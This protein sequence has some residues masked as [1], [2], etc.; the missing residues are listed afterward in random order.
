MTVKQ[1]GY[2]A[3]GVISAVVLYYLPLKFALAFLVKLFLI[4]LF[5]GGGVVIAFVPIDGRPIDVM[6]TNF[7]KAF[8]APNQYIYHKTGRK[9]S[10]S[11]ITIKS[12]TAAEAAAQTTKQVT[13]TPEQKLANKK[14]EQLRALL[15]R[16]GGR[17]KNKLD[18]KEMAFFNTIAAT[19]QPH[20]TT[21]APAIVH[22]VMPKPN[23]ITPPAP[24]AATTKPDTETLAKKEAILTQ[25]LAL[26]K[27]D[28]AA[29]GNTPTALSTAHQK[30]L[31]LE[32]QIQLIHA[33]KQQLEQEII[34]LRNQLSTHLPAAPL[35]ATAPMPNMNMS[36]PA[37][38]HMPPPPPPAPKAIPQPSIRN[39]PQGMSKSMGLPHVSDTPNVVL[40]L[41]KDSRGNALPHMLV[42][43]KDKDG[44]PV[45][46][47]KTNVLGQ[48]ASATPL[49]NGTY[50]IALED[51]K[52]LHSFDTIQINP[53]GQ[54]ML[55]I[56]IISHDAREQLRKELFTN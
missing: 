21:P 1:F 17:V 3:A 12:Q 39:I 16:S 4:P 9:F 52:K 8:F 18:E 30:V 14:E 5:G 10:F 11:T 2:V 24:V 27:R 33:Q 42:E 26:A 40:G 22:P 55:P 7:L 32:K 34:R 28:E 23:P 38:V 47:F 29:A 13:T 49:A 54:I 6:A 41:V 36:M 45:R 50:T 19:P 46:A 31:E 53:H 25:E 15:N 48:F 44:N 37:A 56:E 35:M 20:L 51:P 43:V